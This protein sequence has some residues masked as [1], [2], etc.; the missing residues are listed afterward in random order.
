L[1]AFR[2]IYK[3]LGVD[4]LPQRTRKRR[5]DS[6]NGSSIDTETDIKKDKKEISNTEIPDETT[7][8][9]VSEN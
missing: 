6:E 7:S 5:L 9:N 2:Q 3:I 1:I 8:S 4:P